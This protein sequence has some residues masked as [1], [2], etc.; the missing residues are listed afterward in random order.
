LAKGI[1]NGFPLAAVVTSSEIAATL[2]KALYFNTYGGNPLASR[3]G[4]EVLNILKEEDMQARSDRL[5]KILIKGFAKL[6][7][8]FSDIIED[9]RG[10]GLMI[11]I[12]LISDQVLSHLIF[13]RVENILFNFIIFF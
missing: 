10:K 5:G 12:E 8:D 13:I 3:I 4:N 9:V 11:G 7:D 1:G 2:N 6:R